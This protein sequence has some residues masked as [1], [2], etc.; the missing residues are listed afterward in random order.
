MF[1]K[2]YLGTVLLVV[3]ALSMS[4]LADEPAPPTG[5]L[6]VLFSPGRVRYR[7]VFR[8]DAAG[9]ITGF[10]ERREAWDLV[11]SRVS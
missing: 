1:T 2:L 8:R 10:A 7:Y 9:K 5:H 4:T 6:D 11:W 3:S